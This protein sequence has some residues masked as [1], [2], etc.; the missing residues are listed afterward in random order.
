[1]DANHRLVDVAGVDGLKAQE[2]EEGN[3]RLIATPFH[4]AVRALAARGHEDEEPRDNVTALFANAAAAPEGD[5]KEQDDGD[6]L[7]VKLVR[8][9]VV[10]MAISASTEKLA[11]PVR[12][13]LGHRCLLQSAPHRRKC[14]HLGGRRWLCLCGGCRHP[15][16][17]GGRRDSLRALANHSAHKFI[18][19]SRNLLW[20]RGSQA[21][22]PDTAAVLSSGPRTSTEGGPSWE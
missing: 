17:Q 8:K 10:Q 13:R 21:P 2:E 22:G 19:G 15:H 11:I 9:V 5:E 3:A 16:G 18:Q 20:I 6:V 12:Q 7:L 14:K 4:G 1:M